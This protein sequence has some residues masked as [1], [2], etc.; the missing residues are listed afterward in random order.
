MHVA[1][2][3][4]AHHHPAMLARLIRSLD[5]EDTSFFVHI[6][7]RNDV[8]PFRSAAPPATVF[9]DDRVKVHWYGYS[10]VEATLRL[11]EA[12]FASGA[13]RFVLLSGV[14]Y[15]VASNARIRKTLSSDAEFI[16]IRF[17]LDPAGDGYF[18]RRANGWFFGDRTL[19][20]H[21]EG[22]RRLRK[23]A[24]AV[25]R[26][27]P[28]RRFP[29]PVYYGWAWWTLTRSAVD[30][31]LR[32]R[33]EQPRSFTR[34]RFAEV[35]DEMVFQTLLKQSPRA[36]HIAF[37]QADTDFTPGPHRNALHHIDWDNPNPTLPRTLTEDDFDAIVGGGALFARKTDPKL[38]GNL[39]DRLDA[40]RAAEE[41]RAP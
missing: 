27:L 38:S 29:W 28:R 3:I 22:R 34:F 14:D 10:T 31:L 1:Y 41:E 7:A 32:L 11:L 17:E 23:A 9:L 39:F 30:Y 33:R 24:E 35:P 6:D 15:P 36:G 2:L 4:M 8:A 26:L 37:D 18:D 13:D 5:G 25:G 16:E 12:A 40:W 20:S 19:F 21:R